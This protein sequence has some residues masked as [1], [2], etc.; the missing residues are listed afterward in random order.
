M[1]WLRTNEKQE[2]ISSIRMIVGS[3]VSVSNGLEHWKWVVIALHNSMQGAMVMALRGGNNLRIMP[4]KLAMRCLAANDAGHPWPDERLD[5]FSKLYEKVKDQETMNMF[6][7]SRA[8][9]EE[10]ELK[11]SIKVLLKLRNQFIHFVPQGLS[12]ELSGMPKIC[13]TVLRA[14]QFLCWDSGNVIWHIPEEE[15]TARQ[16][17]ENALALSIELDREYSSARSH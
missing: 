16:E 3:L 5:T 15:R 2:F 12:I 7:T 1:P 11:T 14:I 17:I 6:I 9:P 10:E 13:V 4:Q 8:L